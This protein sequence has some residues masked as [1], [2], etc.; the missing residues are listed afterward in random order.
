[1]PLHLGD[2]IGVPMTPTQV[3]T[4]LSATGIA[5]RDALVAKGQA[6]ITANATFLAITNPTAAQVATQVKLLTREC[7]A[8]IRLL[9][10]QLDS[11]A[12]T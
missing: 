6:A 9:V 12:D 2:V 7:N 8:L 11:T 5:N 1:M 4:A 3:A 10:G